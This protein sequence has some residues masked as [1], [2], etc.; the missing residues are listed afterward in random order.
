MR[1][2]AVPG[3]REN[4]PKKTRDMHIPVKHLANPDIS[5]YHSAKNTVKSKKARS[6]LHAVPADK[7]PLIC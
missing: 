7:H 4:P 6:A 2:K 1:L 3:E 5:H